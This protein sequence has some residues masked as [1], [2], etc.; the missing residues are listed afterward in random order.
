MDQFTAVK[1]TLEESSIHIDEEDTGLQLVPLAHIEAS[2]GQY[3]LHD[4]ALT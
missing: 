1:S 4:H 2:N 3:A